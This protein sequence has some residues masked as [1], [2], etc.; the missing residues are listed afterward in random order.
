MSLKGK[1]LWPKEKKRY[2]TKNLGR[3]KPLLLLLKGVPKAQWGVSKSNS[4]VVNGVVEAPTMAAM[5]KQMHGSHTHN[6]E[7]MFSPCVVEPASLFC[8]DARDLHKWNI[9]GTG[10]SLM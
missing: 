6:A 7:N 4:S 1:K 3:T 2:Q 8:K 5:V 9:T 10:I